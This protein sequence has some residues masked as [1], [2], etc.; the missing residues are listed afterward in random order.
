[1]KAALLVGFGEPL[2]FEDVDPIAPGPNDVRVRLD[3]RGVCHTDLS[4]ASGALPRALPIIPGHEASG[5]VT[6]VGRDVSRV[7]VGDRVIGA[8]ITACGDCWFCVHDRSNLCTHLFEL[9]GTPRA[10]R[11]DGSALPGASGLATFAEEMTVDETL[12]VPVATDLPAEQLA[13][14]GCGVA[15][16]VGAV[17]NTAGVEPGS[18]VA[19]FGCG[20]VG[21]SVVQGA[22]IAGAARIFAIDPVALKRDTAAALG[23]TDTV[24]PDTADPVAQVRESTGGLGVDYA[25]EVTGL[26]SVLLQAYRA[27]RRGGLAVMIGMPRHDDVI[28]FPAFELFMDEKRLASSVYGTT[29]V[30]RDFARLVGMAEAGRLDL[31]ALV[32]RTFALD[33]VNDAMDA[34]RSGE[35]IRAVLV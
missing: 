5:T 20:G 24:N 9:H 22:R 32:S 23:A 18:T 17:L 19:V 31:G 26:P 1:V 4:I 13:L 33:Q 7:K 6:E 2:V 29:Q 8:I 30:R 25:F 11:L 15:T 34:M 21:Q 28:E 27:V 16:G 3:A 10:T 35:V 12:V 14:I